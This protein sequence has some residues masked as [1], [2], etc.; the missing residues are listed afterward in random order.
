MSHPEKITKRLYDLLN[1]NYEVESIYLEIF[2]TIDRPTLKAFFKERGLERRKFCKELRSEIWNIGNVTE[3][4]SELDADFYNACAKLK[5]LI[6][7]KDENQLFDEI[8]TLKKLSVKAYNALLMEP[9]LPLKLCK[10]LSKQRDS[11]QSAMRLL[12]R[13]LDLVA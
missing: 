9:N 1:M 2:N 7:L 6:V 5:N 4:T 8:H 11:I 3:Y 10:V 13:Q 12:T